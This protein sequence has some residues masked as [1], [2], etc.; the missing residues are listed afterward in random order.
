MNRYV[1]WS[2]ILMLCVSAT[3]AAEQL[4]GAGDVI[5]VSVYGSPDLGLE[6]KVSENG[7]ISFPLL[8]PVKVAGIPVS[9]AEKKLSVMLEQG[10]F[11]KSA[12]VNILVTLLQSQQIS[13]LGQVNRPGRYAVDGKRTL[14]DILALAGGTNSEGSDDITL[15][16]TIDGRPAKETVNLAELMRS[17]DMS[18]NPQLNAGDVVYVDRAPRFYIYG[19]VQRAGTYRLDRNM[20]V[21]QALSAGGG[22]NPRGT[23]RGMQIKRRDANGKI[24]VLPA[25]HDEVIQMDDVIYVQ[26]RMF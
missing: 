22:L 8:G 6:T 7:N 1:R 4:L 16:R 24:Q 12:Q 20:S 17:G 10:G 21:V 18:K 15:V 3:A 9:A 25:K 2:A 13:V 14:I 5:K 19:E 26:E 23:E 11:V